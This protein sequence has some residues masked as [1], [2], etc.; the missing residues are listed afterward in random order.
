MCTL[1]HG[2][3]FNAFATQQH[4]P[5]RSVQ[6]VHP[7][8]V[9]LKRTSSR[10]AVVDHPGVKTEATAPKRCPGRKARRIAHVN[11]FKPKPLGGK[12]VNVRTRIP[13]MTVA[14]K[15]IGSETVDIDVDHS[16]TNVVIL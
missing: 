4:H 1:A 15:M 10:T 5:S 2:D 13:V 3:S 14:S 7:P 12:T 9:L 8:D 6:L 16:H 11:A